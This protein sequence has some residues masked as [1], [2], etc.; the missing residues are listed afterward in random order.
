[1]QTVLPQTEVPRYTTT[2]WLSK[3]EHLYGAGLPAKFW[4]AALLHAVY[5][6]NRLV[7]SVTHKTPYEGWYGQKP[8]IAHLKT[9]GS[10]VCVKRTGSCQCK[11]D[12]H[13]F[14]GIFRG[15]TVTDQNI[16]YLNL[17]SGIVKTCHHAIFDE[18]W[19]L[20][21]THPPAAQL[22]YNLGLEAETEFILC[23]GPLHPT[24]PGTFTPISVPCPPMLGTIHND[25]SWKPPPLSLYTPLHLRVTETLHTVGARA[26]RVRFPEDHRSKKDLAANVVSQYLI[27]ASDMAMIYVSP[28]PYGTAFE[29]ELDIRKFDLQCH[30]TAG[31][32]FFEKDNRILL[33]SMAPSTPGS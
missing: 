30:A 17:N 22:L 11:L 32:C 21:P 15:Y 23:H 31:L 5:L 7:H 13:D 26:A 25:K 20:Q 19:Y 24:A 1:V 6:Y 3:Y 33:A 27:G 8:D 10:R 9:F 2:R 4:S 16:T 18:A 12:R 29:E 14:T 28:D